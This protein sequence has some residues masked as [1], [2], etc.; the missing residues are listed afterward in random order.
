MGWPIRKSSEPIGLSQVARRVAFIEV[1]RRGAADALRVG[2]RGVD[3]SRQRLRRVVNECV[4]EGI[5]SGIQKGFYT[6]DLW[7]CASTSDKRDRDCGG[8]EV[9]SKLSAYQRRFC[10]LDHLPSPRPSKKKH[11]DCV[12]CGRLR[13]LTCSGV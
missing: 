6:C 9:G 8:A 7:S 1:S 4:V 5:R 3:Q 12:D 13:G 10:S 2:D 11:V